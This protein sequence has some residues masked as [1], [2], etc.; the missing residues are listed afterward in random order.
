MIQKADALCQN[1]NIPLDSSFY[2]PSPS[3]RSSRGRWG[4]QHSCAFACA[5]WKSVRML[6]RIAF[7]AVSKGWRWIST[8]RHTIALFKKFLLFGVR[9]F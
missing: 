2:N 8:I 1:Y 6:P 5:Y 4:K 7:I 3:P 9:N